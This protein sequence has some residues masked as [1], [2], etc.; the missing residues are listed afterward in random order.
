LAVV[1]NKEESWGRNERV[2]EEEK[3][4]SYHMADL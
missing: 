1:V 4:I 3:K 2:E